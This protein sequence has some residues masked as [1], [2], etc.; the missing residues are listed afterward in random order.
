MQNRDNKINILILTHNQDR[1]FYLV[2]EIIKSKL[3]NVFAI[4]NGKNINKPSLKKKIFNFFSFNNLYKIIFYKSY[5]KVLKEKK[6]DEESFFANQKK[7]FFYSN[8]T[9]L[10]AKVTRINK[11]INDQYFKKIFHHN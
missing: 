1:H 5:F 7:K 10:L 9:N 4:I 2:N 3:G 6:Q 8:S 11:S